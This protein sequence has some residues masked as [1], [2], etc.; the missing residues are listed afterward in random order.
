MAKTLNGTYRPGLIIV[1]ST[2]IISFALCLATVSSTPRAARAAQDLGDNAF[3]LGTI[4]LSE[5]SGMTLTEADFANRVVVG[6]FIFTRCPLSCPKI[7]TVMKGLQSQFKGTN[8]QLLSMTVDP[9]HDT[10]AILADYAK[11]FGADP[12]RWWFATGPP[13]DIQ[14]LIKSRFK[15]GLVA[16]SDADQKSGAEAFAHS[17]RLALIKDAKIIGYFDSSDPKTVQE[18]IDKAKSLDNGEAPA[19]VRQLPAVNA[20][21]NGTCA[22]I[23]ALGWVMIRSG[24]I[25]AHALCMISAVLVSAVFLACYLIY[26]YYAGSVAFQ[27]VGPIRLAYFTILLSHTVLATFGVVPL[28]SITLW[29]ALHKQFDRHSRIARV[30]FPIWMYVSITGVV[31]YLLLY[32]TP[33]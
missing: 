31:I 16:T 24:N 3:P 7:S 28:V 17:D 2:I 1:F 9:E 19:W 29:R 23:L 27:G 4:K 33:V 8:V 15:V 32:K 10:T 6:S 11:R 12:D 5:R 18:L 13:A 21:L 20:T 30:T 14:E 25:K 26:H 22:L